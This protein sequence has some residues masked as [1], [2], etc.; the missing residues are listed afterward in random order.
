MTTTFKFGHVLRLALATALVF[1][2]QIASAQALSSNVGAGSVVKFSGPSLTGQASGS[3]S[4]TV[5]S[6]TGAGSSFASFCVEYQ[7]GFSYN[8]NLYVRGVTTAT[9]N[10]PG[11]SYGASTSD[12][13]S[14]Q[15][16]WLF[17]QYSNGAYS[18]GNYGN[19]V[20]VNDA[21]QQAFWSLEN[22]PGNPPLDPLAQSF[23]T[24]AN[25]AVTSGY[26]TLGNVR[27]LNLYKDAAYTDYAQ[28]QLVMLAPVPEP[29]TYAMLL[30]G[31]GVMGAV[32]RRRKQKQAA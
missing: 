7:E 10:A 29:E 11:G 19:A 8:T 4:G 1:G 9:T 24:F 28:D 6:G 31:L 23:V 21:M 15:T 22:E 2:A 26:A 32:V 16:A 18:N 5:V 20:T 17:T 30:A 3:F 25:N 27:V 12:P 14:F 13:L